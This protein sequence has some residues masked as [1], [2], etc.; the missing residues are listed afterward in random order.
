VPPQKTV[1][2]TGASG[3]VGGRL[4]DFLRSNNLVSLRGVVRSARRA[5]HWGTGDE[6][7]TGDLSDQHIQRKSLESVD[8]VVHLATRGFSAAEIPKASE[9]HEEQTRTLSFVK[10]AIH[11]GVSRFIYV[12]SIHVYGDALVGS[13][14]ETTPTAPNSPYGRSR[15][16]IENGIEE[17]AS[18][19]STQLSVIRLANSFGTPVI[20]RAETWNLLLHD[21]CRQVV[22][23]G[24][25]S[26]RSDPLICRDVIALR[27]VV[28]VLTDL[29]LTPVSLGGV[30][31][32]ASGQTSR[33]LDL[34]QLVG[35]LAEDVL[36]TK[37]RISLPQANSTQSNNFSLRPT[38]LPK[39][40]I[41]IPQNRDEEIR[42]L[43][44]YAQREFG[45]ANS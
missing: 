26:L 32:L 19:T 23:H 34:A 29:I 22:E 4:Y 30:Y 25:I 13:V 24:T 38:R 3:H 18:S 42:D 36:K 43:L 10:A 40:G 45:G 39:I 28:D 1:L 11:A 44:R 21:L 2:V 37:T 17:L 41:T 12:S 9:L 5:Q 35:R 15:Q 6:I 20:P 31:L 16:N 8:C 14:S 7:L 33:L 27:D